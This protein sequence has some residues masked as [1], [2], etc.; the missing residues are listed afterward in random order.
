MLSPL[1]IRI[2]MDRFY[3]PLSIQ[4]SL[5]RLVPGYGDVDDGHAL[6]VGE[7]GE[8]IHRTWMELSLS[9]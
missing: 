5:P 8:V 6:L 4:F 1:R 2:C 7:V 9:H 3:I